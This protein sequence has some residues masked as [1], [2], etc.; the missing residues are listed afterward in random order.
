MAAYESWK[1]S[2][3]GASGSATVMM[4]ALRA[5]ESTPL[6]ARPRRAPAS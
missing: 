1:L 5:M 3:E 6:R 4:M 2:P